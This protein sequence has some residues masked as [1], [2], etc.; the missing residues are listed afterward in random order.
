ME[1]EINPEDTHSLIQDSPEDLLV[2]DVR[3]TWELDR[4]I[5]PGAVSLPLSRF[6]EA[7][8]VLPKHKHLIFY[9]EHGIRSLDAALWTR[10]FPGYEKSQS[11]RKGFSCWQ[12][13]IESLT[14]E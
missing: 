10:R 13:K 11:M 14:G 1:I 12:G 4:G 2:V 5:L 7:T 9:C 8:E 3:E 6:E